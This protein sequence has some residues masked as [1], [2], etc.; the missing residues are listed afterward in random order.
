MGDNE[1]PQE[2]GCRSGPAS[3]YPL[4]MS[5][6]ATATKSKLHL[7]RLEEHGPW[8]D[9]AKCR[10]YD[11]EIFFP[12]KGESPRPAKRICSSCP[13]RLE[14]LNYALRYGVRYGVWGGM[15][16]RERRHLKRIAS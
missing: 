3:A 12:D 10:E 4:R 2:V 1:N 14:C 7:V 6:Q 11:P 16:D 5:P 15:S 13:V 9:L 8:Y